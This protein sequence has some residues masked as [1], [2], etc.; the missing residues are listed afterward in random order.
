MEKKTIK[1]AKIPEFVIGES[2]GSELAMYLLLIRIVIE[3]GTKDGTVK[4]PVS[5]MAEMYG[6]SSKTI[7][8]A[9]PKLQSKKFIKIERRNGKPSVITLL[10]EYS[11]V[12]KDVVG[13]AKF[14][15]ETG[16]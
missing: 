11:G 15:L 5:E 8:R 7:Q 14:P 3:S 1:V 12:H 13:Y 2:N 9:L 6:C 10:D 16:E 4:L